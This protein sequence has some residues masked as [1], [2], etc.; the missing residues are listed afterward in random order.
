MGGVGDNEEHTFIVFYSLSFRV[1]C[2]LFDLNSYLFNGCVGVC[3][4]MIF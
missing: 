2:G 3:M 1:I 4:L